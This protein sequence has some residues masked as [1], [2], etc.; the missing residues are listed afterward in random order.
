MVLRMGQYDGH[1]YRSGAHWKLTPCC[2]VDNVQEVI[3]AK[4]EAKEK[5]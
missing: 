4:K 1:V 2:M 3:R 5:F